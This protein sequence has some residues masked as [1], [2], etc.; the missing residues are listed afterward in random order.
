VSD[1]GHKSWILNAVGFCLM[2]LGRLATAVSFY[3]RHNQIK[4]ELEDWHNA[5]IGYQNLAS[6]NAHLGRL[7]ASAAAAGEAL[8]LARRAE[9]K[10]D[11]RNSL[12]Y[13]AWAAHL[14]G[15][16]EAAGAAFRE[17]EALERELY[18][19]SHGIKTLVSQRGVRHAA[20]LRRV[21]QGDYAR[22][23][24]AA[25]LTICERN[26]WA[27]N[28]SRSHRVLGELDGDEGDHASARD[29]FDEALAIARSISVR[30]VLIETL[31]AR[32]RWAAR[33]VVDERNLAGFRLEKD[34]PLEA[35][36]RDLH[37]QALSDLREALTLATDGGYRVYEAD[38]RAALAWAHLA[39]GE[40]DAARG[41]ATRAITMSRGMGYYW[42][43]V[44][45]EEALAVIGGR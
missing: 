14:R 25:N 13:G 37:K 6:L 19:K 21:G 35:N 7:A 34:P 10:E 45:G 36:P 12:A 8:A 9:N 4:I 15:E 11:E 16:M 18:E 26:R 33:R 39:A 20:H 40:R 23:V 1:P 44:D 2:S 3:E 22:R 27:D 30:D 42:G 43:V 38:I 24:T 31:L 32:G 29:H 5:S 17:A 41:E 28:T